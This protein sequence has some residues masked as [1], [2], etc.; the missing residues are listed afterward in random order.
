V[1][2]VTQR[3]Q[4]KD[5]EARTGGKSENGNEINFPIAIS[6]AEASVQAKL[7][8]TLFFSQLVQL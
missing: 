1:I 5:Q 8:P 4:S 2:K 3:I 6:G 7:F